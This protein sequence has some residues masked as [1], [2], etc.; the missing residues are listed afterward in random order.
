MAEKNEVESFSLSK[1]IKSLGDIAAERFTCGGTLSTSQVQLVYCNNGSWSEATFPGATGTDLRNIIK[2]STFASFGKGKE[3]V[4]D[5]NYR[6]AYALEPKDFMTSFQLCDSGILGEVCACLCPESLHI[7]AELYKMNIYT[8]PTGHFKS[9]VDTPTC[10]EALC[11][12]SPPSS[13]EEA[14]SPGTIDRW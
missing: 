11:C 3:T 14:W 12:A 9:H 8:A 4:T 13:R 5:K 1:I 6:D 7:R 2:S 10:L